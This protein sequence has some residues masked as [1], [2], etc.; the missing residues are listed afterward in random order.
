MFDLFC[1]LLYSFVDIVDPFYILSLKFASPYPEH[2]RRMYEIFAQWSDCLKIRARHS[3][4]TMFSL[5]LFPVY[6]ACVIL[7]AAGSAIQQPQQCSIEG[8]PASSL[9]PKQ[10][11]D[12]ADVIAISI[13]TMIFF[14]GIFV[15]HFLGA[16]SIANV[17]L[18]NQ[19]TSVK[20]ELNPC[21]LHFQTQLAEAQGVVKALV[22]DRKWA[23]KMFD[24]VLP[25]INDGKFPEMNIVYT[26]AKHGQVWHEDRTCRYIRELSDE[27]L[28]SFKPCSACTG[29]KHV[30]SQHGGGSKSLVQ[31]ILAFQKKHIEEHWHTVAAMQVKPSSV[32]QFCLCA[33]WSWWTGMES[34]S[35]ATTLL[36]NL[37]RETRMMHLLGSRLVWL[38]RL[39]ASLTC[40][41]QCK[42]M[43]RVWWA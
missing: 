40:A 1:I 27:A 4:S 18:D 28:K 2:V 35:V 6:P 8:S 43:Q 31:D 11:W 34:A 9:P 37:R 36:T 21:C 29:R 32:H 16:R 33:F 7:L 15:G 26:A 19:V 41:N 13:P 39:S 14:F 20:G 23:C 5:M 30:S 42:G 38:I 25:H 10:E 12:F 22:A 24:R 17:G 3:C